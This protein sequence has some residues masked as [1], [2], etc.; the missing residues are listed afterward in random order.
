MRIIVREREGCFTSSNGQNDGKM[1]NQC[2]L[3]RTPNVFIFCSG[4][5]CIEEIM[6]ICTTILNDWR[7]NWT[8]KK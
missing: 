3:T 1:E 7:D 5:V 2:L 8:K 4:D 6:V